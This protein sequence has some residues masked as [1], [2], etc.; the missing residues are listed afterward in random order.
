M[1][2]HL[3][4]YETRSLIG[5]SQLGL[6]GGLLSF[7][8]LVGALYSGCT[9]ARTITVGEDMPSI[10][11][12]IERAKPGDTIIIAP[13][14][15]VGN[16]EI[17]KDITLRGSGS[18][19][20]ILRAKEG[21][22][23][24][25]NGSVGIESLAIVGGEAG[26][27]V[28]KGS[29]L[30]L[31]DSRIQDCEDGV[32]FDNDFNTTAVMHHNEFVH[33][34]DAIDLEDT[35]AIIFEN[36]FRGN[37]DDA[38]DYDGDAGALVF[39]NR[40]IDSGDDGIEIRLKRITNAVIV[41]N[42]FETTGEDGIE[43]IDTPIKDGPTHNLVL[44]AG[45]TFRNCRRFG[46]G[47]VDQKTE[48]ETSVM[49]Q[50]GLFGC[51]NSFAEC[52]RA[53]ISSN[54]GPVDIRRTS[55]ADKAVVY[56]TSGG[57]RRK[58]ELPVH[59][60]IPLAIYDLRR[61]PDG[62]GVK[63]AEGLALA[64]EGRAFVADDNTPAI[65]ELDL[66]NG[67]LKRM[68]PTAPFPHSEVTATGPEGLC[69]D[70]AEPARLWAANDDGKEVFLLYLEDDRFGKVA[71]RFS[72]LDFHK[73]PEG[74]ERVRDTLYINGGNTLTAVDVVTKALRPGFP[75]VYEF[76]D[77]GNH[78]AGIG[79]D[80]KRL[81]L[82]A[83]A[84]TKQNPINDQGLLFAADLETGEVSEVWSLAGYS[85]DPRGV[86]IKDGL[87]YLVDGY[88]IEMLPDGK[89]PN[90]LGLKVFVFAPSSTRDLTPYVPLLPLRRQTRP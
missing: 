6:W 72:T 74:L 20:T 69:V 75:V 43:L 54:L 28:K 40:I 9:Q 7:I 86:A 15:F 27:Y 83:S 53:D 39:R 30:V 37:R 8:I 61:D 55:T 50:A 1:K 80:G 22:I 24:S 47:G 56:M 65:F 81:I 59:S 49:V 85:N 62:R 3:R 2:E 63:D 29:H 17:N 38:I 36:E 88:G 90:R 4:A 5:R 12:A 66:S 79:Y 25:V 76:P 11:A 45:N 48:E 51:D 82:C 34:K 64:E 33:N 21:N 52:G 70:P 41:D 73:M 57:E 46:V 23:I 78:I 44:I 67:L 87:I 31:S 18:R 16:I 10:Q 60:F 13:G 84:Y 89:E 42:I 14:T 26:V 71:E 35:Q 77:Y 68:I 32:V 58:K 19:N